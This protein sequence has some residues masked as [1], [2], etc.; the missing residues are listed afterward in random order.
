MAA[1]VTALIGGPLAAQQITGGDLRGGLK[2][3]ARWLT[4]SGDYSG[5]RHSPLAEIDA[6]NVSRLVAQWTFQTG[7]AGHKFEASPIVIDDILYVSGPLNHAWAIDGRTGRQIWRYQ[8]QLPPQA[9]LRVCCGLVNR[10]LAVYGDRLFMTTL[11]AHLVALDRQSGRV[12]WDVELAK[13]TEGYAATGAPLIVNDKVIVGVAG[14]EYAIRGFLDAYDPGSGARIW[15]FWTVPA[16]GEPGSE[17]WPA[18]VWERGGG[19]T[20]LTGTYDPELGLLYWG[21]GNPNPDFYGADRSGDNLYTN[22]LIALDVETG[23]LRWHFQFTP[24]DEHDWDANQIPVLV[25][26]PIDGRMRKLVMVANRNGFLYVLDRA[27]GRFIRASPFGHQTWAKAIDSSG[28]PVEQPDQRPTPAGTLTCPDLFGLTNFMSPSFDATTGLFYVTARET[29]QTF[30]SAKPPDGYKAGDR[31]MGGTVRPAPERR[32][33][34]LR[35]ID[36]LSGVVK[37]EIR[38]ETPAWA[39]VLSTAG[40]IVF[41]GDNEGHILAADSRTGRELWR[42]RLGAPL[43]APPATFT[44]AGRQHV[45][46]GSGSTLTAFALPKPWPAASRI[47]GARARGRS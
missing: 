44:I 36:P 35:A 22:A 16:P 12:V 41:S 6:S 24:H 3:P 20:W 32:F 42:Y 5:R 19:P 15:R 13:H 9:E 8:R 34:A 17:T 21:T 29:C 37:W 45:T 47:G 46:I 31:T 11:D 7:L 30:V 1:V 39:G 23:T 38:H 4:Y 10:G 14:G 40:G 2:N 27:N 43:Y 26:A 25:D 18:E 33:G 28:R